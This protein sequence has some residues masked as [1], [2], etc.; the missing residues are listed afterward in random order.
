MSALD[1]VLVARTDK[2]GD[3]MLTWPALA[4]LRAALPKARIDLLVTRAVE[5]IARACPYIDCVIVDRGQALKSIAAEVREPRYEAAVALFVTGRVGMTLLAARVPYRLGPATKAA[6]VCFNHRL[7][8]RR[9]R[10][11]QPEHAYNSDLIRR[12]LGDFDLTVPPE[13]HPPYLAFARDT[14]ETVRSALCARYAVAAE[15]RL[16]V[17]HPGSG[18]SANNLSTEQYAGLANALASSEP[19][20]ILVTAGPGERAQ[21]AALAGQI[22]AHRAVVHDSCD[23]LLAF[24]RVLA[25]ADVF[26]SGSTGPLHIAGAL[27]IRTAA[28]YPR[29]R[30]STALRWQTTNSP[31]R[32]LAFSP[33]AAAAETDM[34]A[35]DIQA[36]AAEINAGFLHDLQR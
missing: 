7:V 24:A 31:A 13:P 15:A 28:F 32:R 33:P 17:V 27:D 25:L 36:A 20:Q 29:R 12:L 19:L 6:Q 35:I 10:S 26:I 1:R 30:S 2:L 16:I 3:F 14:L 8:Q 23:G 11:D 21:A 18:G 22:T 5:E 4:L 34:S 9:S